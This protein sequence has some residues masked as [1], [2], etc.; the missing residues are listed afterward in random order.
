MILS[1]MIF[2]LLQDGCN[3]YLLWGLKDFDWRLQ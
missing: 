2:Y 3:F 1:K